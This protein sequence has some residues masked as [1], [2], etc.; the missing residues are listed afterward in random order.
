MLIKAW[1]MI[2]PK[3]DN[4]EIVAKNSPV[5]IEIRFVFAVAININGGYFFPA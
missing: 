2:L 3:F 5:T 4:I 1:E